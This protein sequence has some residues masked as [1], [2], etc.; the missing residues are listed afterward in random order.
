MSEGCAAIQRDFDRLEKIVERN[1]IKFNKGNAKS[2][3]GG[4]KISIDEIPY[5]SR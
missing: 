5:F 1:L 4:Q 3:V 2:Y